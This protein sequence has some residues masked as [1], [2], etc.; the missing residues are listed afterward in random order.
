M[1]VSHVLPILLLNYHD[2]YALPLHSMS[3]D[4]TPSSGGVLASSDTIKQVSH[5]QRTLFD[6][7]WSCAITALICAW[8][9]VH[10]NVPPQIRGRGSFRK[11][12]VRA[13]LTFWAIVAP[14]LVV[15]WAVQQWLAARE[16]RDTYNNSFR[17][18]LSNRALD[19]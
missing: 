10:P 18:V 12:L 6:V 17:G 7:V 4:G 11:M 2:G 14:E 9:S 3:S 13:K 15:V 1:L 19:S 5:L 16:I 8:T